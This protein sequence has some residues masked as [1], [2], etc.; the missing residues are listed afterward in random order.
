MKSSLSVS[1]LIIS[2]IYEIYMNVFYRI[3]EELLFR[4]TL[5]YCSPLPIRYSGIFTIQSCSL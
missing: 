4:R 1:I 3:Y 2:W 5:P